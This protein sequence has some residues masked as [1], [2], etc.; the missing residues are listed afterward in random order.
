MM[1]YKVKDRNGITLKASQT[2]DSLYVEE[3]V[4]LFFKL[5]KKMGFCNGLT[6]TIHGGLNG[7]SI[8]RH[9]DED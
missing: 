2:A 9:I 8:V 7:P 4:R 5:Y 1:K 6:V 3:L